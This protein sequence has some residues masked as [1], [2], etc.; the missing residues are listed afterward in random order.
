[1]ERRRKDGSASLLRVDDTSPDQIRFSTTR[2]SNGSHAPSALPSLKFNRDVT[3]RRSVRSSSDDLSR[4]LGICGMARAISFG[5]AYA[6]G[7]PA[8]PSSSTFVD[9]VGLFVRAGLRFLDELG[10]RDPKR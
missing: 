10:G 9:D 8:A 3:H 1:V 5:A 6:S 7:G 2:L 4:H